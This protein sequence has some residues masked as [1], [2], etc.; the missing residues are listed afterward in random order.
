MKTVPLVNIKIFP[1][2]K[3]LVFIA[4]KKTKNDTIHIDPSIYDQHFDK[5]QE[6]MSPPLVKYRNN[7]GG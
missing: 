7:P 2:S 4:E 1:Y 6:I 5:T 3:S